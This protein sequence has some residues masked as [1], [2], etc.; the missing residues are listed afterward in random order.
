MDTRKLRSTAMN[1]ITNL[2]VITLANLE[3]SRRNRQEQSQKFWIQVENET[4]I[5]LKEAYPSAV[6]FKGIYNTLFD[7][8]MLRSY[9]TC[10]FPCTLLHSYFILLLCIIASS[11]TKLCGHLRQ[12][13]TAFWTAKDS[14]LISHSYFSTYRMTDV[15]LLGCRSGTAQKAE[16]SRIQIR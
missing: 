10:A 8:N 4:D 3:M 12:K 7:H 5:H 6:A 1:T 13:I 14:S 15:K 16:G 11:C 2:E 9:K